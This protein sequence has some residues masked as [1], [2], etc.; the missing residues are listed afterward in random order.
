MDSGFPDSSREEIVTKLLL[1]LLEILG[2]TTCSFCE[3]ILF[4]HFLNNA[5]GRKNKMALVKRKGKYLC[6]RVPVSI[7]L[8]RVMEVL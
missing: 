6:C 1:I 4:L 2:I 8:S 5:E 7:L 3:S